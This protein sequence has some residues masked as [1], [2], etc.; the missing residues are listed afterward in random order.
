[1]SDKFEMVALIVGA[2]TPVGAFIVFFLSKFLM[3]RKEIWQLQMKDERHDEDIK[4]MK[5]DIEE[6]QDRW[7]RVGRNS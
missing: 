2:S 3:A 6:L 1:M 4:D 5:K 7:D